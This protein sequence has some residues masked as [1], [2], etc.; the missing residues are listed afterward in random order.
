M[1]LRIKF[2]KKNYLKYIS[3]LDLMRLFRRSFNRAGIP[4]EYSQGFNPQPRFSIASPLSLGIESEEEYMDI[5][6]EYMPVEEFIEKMN[7][8]LPKDVQIIDGA[9]LER[10]ESVAALIAW[11]F[12]EIKF[13][14]NKEYSIEELK[15]LFINWLDNEEILLKRVR[16]KGRRNIEKEV[17]IKEL[18]GNVIVKEIDGQEIKLEVL[19][20]SGSQGN[21]NP[22]D[23]ITVFNRDNPVEIEEDSISIK[24]LSL[25]GEKDNNLFRPL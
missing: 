9:Y 18:I 16:K 5:Y 4:V 24:R 21:L 23:F 1:I 22:T 3:H 14:V 11:A 10:D 20:K 13:S 12:Y 25:Y 7:N 8:V 15:N 17:N 6:L 19:L 2:N